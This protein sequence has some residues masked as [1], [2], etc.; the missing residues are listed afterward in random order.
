MKN[1]RIF[2]SSRNAELWKTT[3]LTY[4]ILMAYARIRAVRAVSVANTDKP[5]FLTI[6]K[7][8]V[9][10]VKGQKHADTNRISGSDQI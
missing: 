3:G 7:H 10:R 1:R 4:G 5:S 6:Q 9:E 2:Q 8:H